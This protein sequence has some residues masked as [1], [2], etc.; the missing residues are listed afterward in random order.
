MAEFVIWAKRCTPIRAVAQ[1]LSPPPV[2]IVLRSILRVSVGSVALLSP[3]PESAK[4]TLHEI[5]FQIHYVAACVGGCR[6]GR[7]R[8]VLSCEG[9]ALCPHS[10]KHQF[11]VL[12]GGRRRFARRSQGNGYGSQSRDRWPS[13]IFSKRRS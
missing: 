6:V 7:L 11:A 13:L 5:F 2:V 1:D 8:T 9:R 12:A 4:E 3:S 10:R